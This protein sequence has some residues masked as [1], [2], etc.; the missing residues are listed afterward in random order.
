MSVSILD[1]TGNYLTKEMIKASD[2]VLVLCSENCLIPSSLR[3]NLLK[4]MNSSEITKGINVLRVPSDFQRGCAIG[5]LFTKDVQIRVF[6]SR[7]ELFAGILPP[8]IIEYALELTHAQPKVPSPGKKVGKEYEDMYYDLINKISKSILLERNL[9]TNK[10]QKLK[11]QSE[12]FASGVITSFSKRSGRQP[13]ENPQSLTAAVLE[14]LERESVFQN[15]Q[16][17]IEYNEEMIQSYFGSYKSKIFIPSFLKDYQNPKPDL[18]RHRAPEA[19]A[20]KPAEK[21]INSGRFPMMNFHGNEE[22][23]QAR[24]PNPNPRAEEEKFPKINQINQIIPKSPVP[25]PV[26]QV[27]NPSKTIGLTPISNKNTENPDFK[28]KPPVMEAKSSLNKKAADQKPKITPQ[29]W[30]RCDE[31]IIDNLTEKVGSAQNEINSLLSLYKICTTELRDYLDLAEVS[32]EQSD[33]QQHLKKHMRFMI[34]L[35]FVVEGFKSVDEI[36]E[37]FNSN[38]TVK[39]KPNT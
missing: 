22:L 20:I 33:H 31:I 25:F 7:R 32:Y 38:L 17:R 9:R 36:L 34:D 2:I 35:F 28:L 6:T 14:D 15:L 5:F 13:T 3:V 37:N 30:S 4:D 24:F 8:A 21:I 27:P 16:G 11:S 18:P 29:G 19:L 26:D 23:N 10:Y 12:N 1:F 39:L